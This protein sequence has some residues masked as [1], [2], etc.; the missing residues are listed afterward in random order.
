MNQFNSLNY[1]LYTKISSL[2]LYQS[3]F[4]SEVSQTFISL[5]DTL[6]VKNKN[7]LGLE[8]LKSYGFFFKAL[9]KTGKSWQDYLINEILLNEN[10]F[11]KQVQSIAFKELPQSLINAVKHDLKILQIISD[12]T[13]KQIAELV[14]SSTLIDYLPLDWEVK[15]IDNTFLHRSNDW[16]NTI[17][18]LANYYCQQ[19]TGIHTKYKALKWKE[20]QLIGIKNPDPINLTEIVGYDLQKETLIKN[21]EI[22]LAGH[23]ALNILLYGSRGSGKSS[24]VKG[25]LTR[26]SDQGLRLVEVSKHQLSNLP[27]ISNKLRDCPQKFIIF[28]DDLSFEEHDDSFK[29][30]KVVLEGSLTARANNVVVYATSNRKHLI[31]EFFSDRPQPS[32]YDEVHVWDTMQEKL[33]FS[34]RFGLTLTFQPANQE[35]YLMIVNHLAQQ[36]QLNLPQKELEFRA[37]QW[38]IKHNGLS[39]RTA[40]QFIYFLQGELKINN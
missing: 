20:K 17:E 30:L 23:T 5:L 28:V 31:K 36:V 15:S 32:E 6:C 26:Y 16:Q 12:C 33:S 29:S 19:G 8:P 1:F 39:G 3:V 27:L 13:T 11:S 14:K 2:L 21:T 25:L 22:L 18:E 35:K 24:L 4:E 10:P 40:R 7:T 38:A 9:A 34:D 37:K